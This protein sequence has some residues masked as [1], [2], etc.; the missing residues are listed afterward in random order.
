MNTVEKS[1]SDVATTRL[2]VRADATTA[3]P[4]I[5]LSTRGGRLPEEIL[6][7]AV[8]RL[9]NRE[10]AREM[11][12]SKPPFRHW[13]SVR[14]VAV[15]NGPLGPDHAIYVGCANWAEGAAV[16]A[17]RCDYD[18]AVRALLGAVLEAE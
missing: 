7:D 16:L 15:P 6:T 17:A 18:A 3:A 2:R 12:W 1:L 14:R 8:A 5:A 11:D 10:R 13:W 4:A 9:A